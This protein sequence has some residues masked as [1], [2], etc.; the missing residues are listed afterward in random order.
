MREFL[1]KIDPVGLTLSKNKVI[2]FVI[3]IAESR[4]ND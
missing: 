1:D 4:G 3:L 2:L